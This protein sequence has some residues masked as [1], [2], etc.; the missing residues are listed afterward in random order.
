MG[1]IPLGGLSVFCQGSLAFEERLLYPLDGLF[2][3]LHLS[4]VVRK[5]LVGWWSLFV[6]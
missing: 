4:R 5:D 6:I 3:G 2:A 1:F